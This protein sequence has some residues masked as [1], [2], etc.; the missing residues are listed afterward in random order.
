MN[1]AV[2]LDRDGVINVDLGYVSTAADFHFMD[3][4]FHFCRT[5]QEKGYII[6]VVTNQA[7]IAREYYTETDFH[8]LNDWMLGQFERHGVSITKTYY[9][10]YHFEH[11]IGK[12]KIDSPDRKPNPGMILRASKEFDINLPGS[13]LVGDKDDDM[14]AAYRAGMGRLFFLQGKYN[15]TCTDFPY[16]VCNNFDEIL[17]KLFAD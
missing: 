16:D 11:G 14:L 17:L 8:M 2:F 7:G 15:Y 13:I 5:M 4:I 10:P 6:I 12:Y 1:K 3:G 9:C